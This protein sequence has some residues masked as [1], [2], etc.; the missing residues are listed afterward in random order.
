MADKET[1]NKSFFQTNQH[2]QVVKNEVKNTKQFISNPATTLPVLLEKIK[3]YSNL[4]IAVSSAFVAITTFISIT[5][6]WLYLTQLEAN[7]LFF[8]S[9]ASI[10]TLSIII[11]GAI[12]LIAMCL[13]LCVPSISAI[14]TTSFSFENNKPPKSLLIPYLISPFIF[15][16]SFII[17]SNY[18]KS[19]MWTFILAFLI[20][21][22]ISALPNY[23]LPKNTLSHIY[24][25]LTSKGLFRKTDVLFIYFSFFI[26][27]L[28][29]LLSFSSFYRLWTY[30]IGNIWTATIFILFLMIGYVPGGA[31]IYLKAEGSSTRQIIKWVTISI[32]TIFFIIFIIS[33]IK[34]R[35]SIFNA[36]GIFNINKTPNKFLLLNKDLTTITYNIFFDKEEDIKNQD[37]SSQRKGLEQFKS[38]Y[39]FSAYTTYNLGDVHLLC[40][41]QINPDQSFSEKPQ[42]LK[43]CFN[44]KPSEIR[45]LY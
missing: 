27:C 1:Q 8:S 4:V 29:I 15:L 3:D 26:A 35:T 19:L 12:L 30:P 9:V 13:G 39:E 20:P 43:N 22:I 45:K 40:K 17:L 23:F 6:I 18:T 44:Y 7:D 36:V 41:K 33:P 25:S 28:C 38:N 34:V 14:F 31:Y 16:I 10:N 5:S 21:V 42:I 24:N 11:I 37:N 2:V 32:I